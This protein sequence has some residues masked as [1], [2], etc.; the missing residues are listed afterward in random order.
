MHSL[1]ILISLV[2]KEQP[3]VDK[4]T[5]IIIQ[6]IF[7]LHFILFPG[8]CSIFRFEKTILYLTK[9]SVPS[10]QEVQRAP[11]GLA[12]SCCSTNFFKFKTVIPWERAARSAGH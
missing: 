10:G 1:N 3:N 4:R 8:G 5:F 7:K 2:K 12:T 9:K 11:G 6:I